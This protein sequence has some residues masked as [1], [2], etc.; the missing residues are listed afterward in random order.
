MKHNRNPLAKAIN[1]AL[2]A[3]MI[4]GLA[5][6]ASPVM[7]QDGEAA[8]DLDRVQVTGSRISRLDVE[9][10]TPVVTISREDI[11]AT[12][13]QSVADLLRSNS[14]NVVGSLREDSGNTAQGQA[15]V[16]MRG[17]GSARTLILLNGRRLPGS[18]VLDGQTQNLN[19]IPFAAVDRIEIL[20]D[21]ASAIYGSDAIGGVINI[22]LRDDFDGVEVTARRQISDREGGDEQLYSVVGGLSSD[23]GAF[24]YALEKRR[25]DI[26]WSRDREFFASANHGAAFFDDTYNLST[27]SRNLL[28][29]A[30][31]YQVMEPMVTSGN[32]DVYGP[33]HY[34][35]YTD[36]WGDTVCAYDFTGVM[37]DSASLD[38]TDLFVNAEYWI[39]D[40]TRV[41]ARGQH[42]EVESFGRYAPAAGGFFSP[43]HLPEETLAD[44]T[45]LNEIMPNDYILYRFDMT[46]PGRDT[47][48]VDTM[49]DLQLGFDGYIGNNVG[50]EVAIQHNRYRMN[51]WGDGYVNAMGS[52][53]AMQGGWDPRHPDQD[54]FASH[55]AN[56]SENANRRAEMETKRIDGGFSID[57]PMMG[58][59]QMGFF[60]GAEYYEE[61]Y[62]DQ[63]QA[64]AAAGNIIGTAGG[65]S[66]G[67]RDVMALYGEASFPVL[68]TLS[69]D[70]ALR[71]DDY[72]DFGDNLSGRAG[73]RW[74]PTDQL[75]VRG[76]YG[77]GFRAPSLDL[78]A[79]APAQSFA[80]GRD[81]T[82]CMG[83]TISQVGGSPTFA[84]DLATCLAMP[85]QQHQTYFGSN[86]NLQAEESEQMNI[87]VVMDFSDW[88]GQSLTA[89]LDYYWIEIDDT[90]TG[91]GVQDI[92]W[93]HFLE[94]TALAPGLEYNSPGGQPT[95]HV[96]V[97]TN[98]QSFDTSGL[99]LNVRY[100]HDAGAAGL[101]SVNWMMSYVLEYNSRFLVPSQLQDFTKTTVNEW[102]TDLTLGWRMGDHSVD[103]H[104]WHVP[105]RCE[106]NTLD[107]SSLEDASLLAMCVQEQGG[108]DREIGSFTHHNVSYTYHLPWNG[109]LTLGVNNV[110]DKM[111]PMAADGV[112]FSK[113]M[114]PYVGR[115]YVVQYRQNF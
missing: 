81:I 29:A 45:V 58:G 92:L 13:Y 27:A 108:G 107:Q 47:W 25:K 78:L 54:Q 109:A 91:I 46:G 23:R 66:G 26:I 111:P 22:I 102:R 71:Y 113:D 7:A 48:Q 87:G 83:G 59:G 28:T 1:Y 2:G 33:D 82:T 11:D 37:A 88:I 5:V 114:Y 67:Y 85:Q 35:P 106:A 103:W 77:T 32:C 64:Q 36:A 94:N 104:V 43:V 70:V 10:A 41:W 42:N 8:A 34:G 74:Q 68:D 18:P 38:T 20:Y 55:V 16:N 56:M 93:L 90:I 99:D 30:S 24:T 98:F 21:G 50:W 101:F 9:G 39:N 69:F 96:S 40:N 63:T 19:T 53:N 110:A 115:Q 6:T 100:D 14:F 62:L 61:T 60:V 76:S 80:F 57:G 72:S 49:N 17:I 112:S 44:G 86:P 84:D 31:G 52:A 75:L 51:E 105:G 65:S 95:P 15:T 79:Q 97:P 89:S 4:A 3:G 12:G 73:V